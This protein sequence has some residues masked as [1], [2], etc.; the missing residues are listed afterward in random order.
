[1]LCNHLKLAKVFNILEGTRITLLGQPGW[2]SGLAPH[3]AQGVILGTRDQV[4][5][6]FPCMEPAFRSACVSVSLSLSL[7]VSL[8]NK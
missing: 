1:M 7:C 2:L 5:H 3:S 6:R 8:M 4:P